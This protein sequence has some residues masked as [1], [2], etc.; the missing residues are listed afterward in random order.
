[1]KA[2]ISPNEVVVDPNT[3]EFIGVRVCDIMVAAFEV[4]S[5]LFWVDCPDGVTSNTH[6][7]DVSSSTINAIPEYVPPPQPVAEGVQTL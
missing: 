5:P 1:M 2:L 3:N 7:Y 4:A 6:Y